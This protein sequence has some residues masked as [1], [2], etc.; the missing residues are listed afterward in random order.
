MNCQCVLKSVLVGEEAEFV[1]RLFKSLERK[2]P[3]GE[4]VGVIEQ[5]KRQ[6]SMDCPFSYSWGFKYY[7][8]NQRFIKQ[9]V[10][11]H[12]DNFPELYEKIYD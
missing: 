9:Y 10:E 4:M 11:Q 12:K 7:C 6:C 2:G 3:E 5:A 1:R 8:D